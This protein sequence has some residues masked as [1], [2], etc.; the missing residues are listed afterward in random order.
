MIYARPYDMARSVENNMAILDAFV[1][2]PHFLS[3]PQ[4]P[5]AARQIGIW[6]LTDPG[7]VVFEAWRD[8]ELLGVMLLTRIQPKVDALVHFLFLDKDLVGKRKLLQNF[9]DFC[10]TELEF[11]RL[12][13]EVPEGIRL[14]RFAR[15]VLRFR[16]EGE[17]R[18]RN[19]ELPKSLSDSWVARQGSRTEQ[20]YFDGTTWSDILRLRLLAS[21][22]VGTGER[23]PDCQSELSSV[24]P[25]QSSAG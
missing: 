23:G 3:Y 17:I 22:W 11:H 5:F 14:E 9:I 13:M 19:P 6:M 25:H 24:P 4:E 20:G 8:K 1:A 2:N 12:S 21:E 16:L 15:K 10:F 18:P 7:H